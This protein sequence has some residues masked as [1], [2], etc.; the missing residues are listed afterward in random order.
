M[1]YVL[2]RKNGKRTSAPFIFTESE[3]DNLDK[4]KRN[5]YVLVNT[6]TRRFRRVGKRSRSRNRRRR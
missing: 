5:S 2:W 6:T 1:P 3:V 4:D